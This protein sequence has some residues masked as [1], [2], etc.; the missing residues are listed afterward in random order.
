MRLWGIVLVI[1]LA[2]AAGVP[3][4]ETC[5][6]GTSMAGDVMLDNCMAQSFGLTNQQITDLRAQ[7][8]SNSDIA[9]AAVIASKACVPVSTIVADYLPCKSWPDVA[10]KY[11]LSMSDLAINPAMM[12][13]DNETFNT[14]FISQYYNIPQS[15]IQALRQQGRP[16][17]EVNMIANASVRTGQ[18]MQQ[19][20]ALRDQGM[21]WSDIAARCNLAAATLTTPCPP[22]MVATTCPPRTPT[23]PGLGAGPVCTRPVSPVIFDKNG[24]VLLT[25]DEALRYYAMGNDWLNVAIASNIARET[26]Y[27]IRLILQDLRW[28]GSTWE[29][30]AMEYAVA[31][32]RAFNVCDYPFPHK[33]IYSQST[34]DANMRRIERYQVS[35]TTPGPTP[36]YSPGA[37]P[38]PSPSPPVY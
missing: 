18:S 11:N 25:Q 31:P 21:S 1:S 13:A 34:Q 16:W 32:N 27:P 22:R 9:I 10:K 3:A 17:D 7:G 15:D 5:P 24:N 23:C 26:G 4:A 14:M 37:T 36:L 33:S 20:V 2:C 29:Q 38:L 30:V 28:S 35:T 6:P 12:N 19:I 8:L